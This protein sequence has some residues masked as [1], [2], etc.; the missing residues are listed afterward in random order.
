[1]IGSVERS[2]LLLAL[3]GLLVFAEIGL[4]VFFALRGR[5]HRM[6]LD[7]RLDQLAEALHAKALT[8]D[9]R[10]D[11]L[12]RRIDGLGAVEARLRLLEMRDLVAELDR[13]GSLDAGQ[14]AR[15]A[16]SIDRLRE[17]L[18]LEAEG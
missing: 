7:D 10:A 13:K 17:D 9:Q 8:A 6:R 15:L 12:G 5:T 2:E 1:M 3:L 11:E 18:R 16:S 14:T 4:S